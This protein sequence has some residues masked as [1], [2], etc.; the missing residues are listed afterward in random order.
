MYIMLLKVYCSSF[1]AI[2]ACTFEWLIDG[3]SL[4]KTKLNRLIKSI[5][6]RVRSIT[7]KAK[8]GNCRVKVNSDKYRTWYMKVIWKIQYKFAD[9]KID[10]L[11]WWCSSRF[12]R[13]YTLNNSYCEKRHIFPALSFYRRFCHYIHVVCIQDLLEKSNA[14]IFYD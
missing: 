14:E 2:A 4:V 1:L 5:C 10:W 8:H 7:K 13:Y 6:F 3:R 9:A 11:T 12:T